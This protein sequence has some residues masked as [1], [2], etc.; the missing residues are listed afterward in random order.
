[1]GILGKLFNKKTVPKNDFSAFFNST[2]S[3]EKERF[4]EEIARKA[5]EDQKKL[6]EQYNKKMF[7]KTT[8]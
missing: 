3:R 8:S 1:M 4:L 5:N 6:M 7:S 2:E